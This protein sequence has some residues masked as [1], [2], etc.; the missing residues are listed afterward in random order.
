MNKAEKSE[1][2]EIYDDY[3]FWDHDELEKLQEK[4]ARQWLRLYKKML[5]ARSAGNTKA[6]EKAVEALQKHEAQD[7]ILKGKSQQCGYYWY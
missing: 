1:K 5:D 2:L 6:L 7:R 4:R 3:D